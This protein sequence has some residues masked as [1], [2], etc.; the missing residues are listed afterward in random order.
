MHG[1]G[2]VSRAE[3]HQ[4]APV[5]EGHDHAGGAEGGLR[6]GGRGGGGGADRRRDAQGGLWKKMTKT[7]KF[8]YY[9]TYSS[10]YVQYIY[11]SCLRINVTFF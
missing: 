3:V 2:A 4:G 8:T 11:C 1:G 10:G 5:D 7:F 9:L 6:G